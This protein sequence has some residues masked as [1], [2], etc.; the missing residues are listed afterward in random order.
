MKGIEKNGWEEPWVTLEACYGAMRRDLSF[1]E[2]E[3]VWDKL[4]KSS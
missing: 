2:R 1:V 4:K 3:K